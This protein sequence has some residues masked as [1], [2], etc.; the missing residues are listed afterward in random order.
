MSDHPCSKERET[1]FRVSAP[2][3]ITGSDCYRPALDKNDPALWRGQDP[4]KGVRFDHLVISRDEVRAQMSV[5]FGGDKIP[6]DDL[7]ML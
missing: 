6:E 1:L 2:N 3:Q 7:Y 4:E 5:D